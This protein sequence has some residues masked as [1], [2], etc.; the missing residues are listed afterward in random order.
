[1]KPTVLST[2]DFV[3]TIGDAVS[4]PKNWKYQGNKPAVVDFH[5]PWCSYCK[6]LYPI[7]DELTEEYKDKVDF[8]TV[9]VDQEEPLETAFNIRTIPTL[10]LCTPGGYKELTLG[11]MPKNELK[12]LID[13][14]LL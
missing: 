8:Y 1:M 10:L 13:E 7:L 12:K 14:K 2:A 3:K 6:R 5:A 4:D 11:T 9:D